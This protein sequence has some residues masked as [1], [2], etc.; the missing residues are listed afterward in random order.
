MIPTIVTGSGRV[1]WLCWN[2]RYRT[3][4]REKTGEPLHIE[5]NEAARA[6]RR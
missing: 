4:R 6:R 1:Y 5:F 2:V 3:R